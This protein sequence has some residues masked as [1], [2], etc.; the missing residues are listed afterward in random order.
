[1]RI[2]RY[3]LTFLLWLGLALLVFYFGF[4]AYAYAVL[5]IAELVM[6][7]TTPVL[8]NLDHSDQFGIMLMYP[9]IPQPMVFRANL[10]SVTLNWI[11]VPALVLTTLTFVKPGLLLSLQRIVI[12]LLIMLLLHALHVVLILL[13]FLTQATNPL[14][15]PDFPELL[16]QFI[17][18]LYYFVD[19]MAYTLFPFIAW[20][21]VCFVD[22]MAL[23]SP[24]LSDEP[25]KSPPERA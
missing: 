21:A 5:F 2:S 14:I 20:I 4:D 22:I 16:A 13:H 3:L 24:Q 8:V 18:W 9:G 7:L 15:P 10:F 11:F 23:L 17:H 25:Q 6:S 19:K 12:A 1:M